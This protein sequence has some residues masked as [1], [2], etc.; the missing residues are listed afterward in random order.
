MS[1]LQRILPVLGAVLLVAC[2]NAP[3]AIVEDGSE[4]AG[5]WKTLTGERPVIIAHRGASGYRPEHTLEAYALAID[6]GADV[7]EP[8]LVI[9]R[10][11][12]LVARHDRY[13]ST[14][15]NVADKPEFADRRRA[16]PDTDDDPRD[17]WW[18][19]DFTL[20]EIK[21][22]RARQPFDGRSKNFDDQFEIPTFDEVVA[23]VNRK[24]EEAGRPVGVYPET[25]H[26]GYFA[27]IGLDF[28]RPLLTSLQ[29]FAGGPVFI[30]S[31]EPEILQRLRGQTAARLVQLVYEE[32]PGAGPN[33][34]L[35]D[36]IAYADGVGPSKSLL[37]NQDG[38][39]G[40]VDE[41]HAL[42][43]AV[44]PWTFRDDRPNL[45]LAAS[46]SRETLCGTA[47]PTQCEYQLFYGLG[48]DGLFTDFPDTAI[49]VRAAM[50][51]R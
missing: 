22:L 3:D 5:D 11:G 32:S 36:M 4:T 6:Q 1:V 14:T 29:A 13:L 44:H 51:K 20:Q 48:V 28:E 23:L 26:P 31:F 35:A 17:D 37:F 10:D 41:A 12:A 40:F 25:K 16:N 46:G 34:P 15:T 30:Q 38:A 43:L 27:S 2:S 50:A 42:G 39:T 24:A 33:I 18:V 45:E 9:T 8:D 47:A 7:I 21:S 19:E 49:A